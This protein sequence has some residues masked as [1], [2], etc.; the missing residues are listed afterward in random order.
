MDTIDNSP[1]QKYAK[2]FVDKMR[3]M[4]F[5]INTSR[6]EKAYIELLL[7]SLLNGI[8]IELH[9][10]IVFVDSDNQNT[11]EMLIEQK[12]V[13]PNLKIIK[14]TGD[15]IGY[16]SNINYLFSI[17]NTEI[18]SYLQSDQVVCLNYD[19][20][21]YGI[22]PGMIVSSTR[23]EP[24]L[25]A[26]WDN[27]I[28]L[29]K[30]F[31]LTPDTFQYETFLAYADN[32]KQWKYTNYFFAP[33][34]CHKSTWLNIN[35]HDVRFRKS[36]ED[37]D[38][39]IRLLLNGVRLYQDWRAIVYHFTCTSSRQWALPEN[40]NKNINYENDQIELK[41]FV[42]KWG[43]FIH[44]STFEDVAQFKDQ[45]YNIIANNPPIDESKFIVY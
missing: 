44:P 42:D 10:I 21:F 25:H 23:V 3:K 45:A 1:M 40:R 8:D 12:S 31:G 43:S 22:K 34:T 19:H 36:R 7:T 37:S 15:P 33:F 32:V 17:A 24:P 11:T 38:V 4:T 30:D 9:D 27:D 26:K 41:R 14:N 16:A 20:A 29:V 28:T 6:N 18:V 39:A 35:G 13:F 2:D 5:V